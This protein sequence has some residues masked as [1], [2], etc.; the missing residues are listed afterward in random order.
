MNSFPSHIVIAP[1]LVPLIT[2]AILLFID[3]R[4]RKTKAAISFIST[5]VLLAVSICLF[6]EVNSSVNT[7][8]A[9]IIS[10]GCR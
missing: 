10:T 9:A 5:L 2:G 3:E 4:K 1:I 8:I 7:E 6:I